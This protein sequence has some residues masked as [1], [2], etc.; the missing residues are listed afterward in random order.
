MTICRPFERDAIYRQDLLAFSWKAFEVLNP[1]ARWLINWHIEKITDRLTAVVE[2]R[3]KRLIINLQPRTLKSHL[4][5]V[6]L[7]AFLLAKDPTSKIICLSY[8]QDLAS[9]H[10]S[11]CR[12]LIESP[13]YRN[14]NPHFRLPPI[15]ES[16]LAPPK[17]AL[18]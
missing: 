9:K 17:P 10:A 11:D 2:G 13:F 12:R 8:S 15:T 14:L 18:R 5:S 16:H 1:G 6:A 4:A 7:P 3:S